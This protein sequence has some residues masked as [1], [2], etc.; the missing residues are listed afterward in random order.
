MSIF[1]VASVVGVIAQSH[2]RLQFF[3]LGNTEDW[4]QSTQNRKCVKKYIAEFFACF[5]A[6]C[7]GTQRKQFYISNETNVDKKFVEQKQINCL[8]LNFLNVLCPTKIANKNTSFRFIGCV[9]N[10]FFGEGRT[11]FVDNFIS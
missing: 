2:F 7:R 5:I 9:N 3:L 11:F 10:F 8:S 4:I 6:C 1:G